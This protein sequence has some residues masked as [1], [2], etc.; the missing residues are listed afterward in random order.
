[1]KLTVFLLSLLACVAHDDTPMLRALKKKPKLVSVCDC[2]GNATSF[3][4]VGS[5][6][7]KTAAAAAILAANGTAFV[8]KCDDVKF[9]VCKCKSQLKKNVTVT[10]CETE[11][12]KGSQV[13]ALLKKNTTRTVL[14]ACFVNTTKPFVN[15]TNHSSDSSSDSSED[16][17]NGTSTNTTNI[18]RV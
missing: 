10:K 12:V 7:N 4:C 14:G 17:V 2:K 6:Y 5:Q 8:G 13:G 16:F 11:K 9:R 18:T 15:R 1:M 3:S